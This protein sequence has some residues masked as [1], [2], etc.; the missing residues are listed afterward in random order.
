MSDERRYSEDEVREIFDRAA[1]RAEGV[2]P[3]SQDGLT[4]AELQ[5]IG[6]EVGLAPEHVAEAASTLAVALKPQPRRTEFG[7]PVSVGRIVELPRAPTGAE[8]ERLVAELH[9]T[10]GARG[11]E[12]T[13]GNLREWRNGNLH[14]LIAPSDA[15][16]R[17]TLGTTKGDAAAFN[18]MGFGG[19]AIALLI[20]IVMTLSGQFNDDL[21]AAVVFAVGG[22]AALGYNALRLPA[23]AE[24]RE[25][26]M[27]QIAER[28]RALIA[29]PE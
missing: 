29:A 12:H 22:G 7:M 27:E 13:S 4:L 2:A 16:Y 24:R 19:L 5:A 10:F 23:W 6:R 21:M 17:L 15:G 8:W 11:S 25:A 14:A 3:A 1:A 26:Q 28:A 9:S 20:V 18:R